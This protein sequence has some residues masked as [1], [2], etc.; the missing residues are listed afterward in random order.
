[1]GVVEFLNKHGI[2]ASLLDEKNI[3]EDEL[4][5]ILDYLYINF[6]KQQVL[7]LVADYY[8]NADDLV[9]DVDYWCPDDTDTPF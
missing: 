6:T 4:F 7:D 9:N 2:N 1:M 8:D 5:D 3:D